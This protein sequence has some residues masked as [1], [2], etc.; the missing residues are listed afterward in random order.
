MKLES[1]S[2]KSGS[3]VYNIGSCHGFLRNYRESFTTIVKYSNFTEA[4][5]AY[6]KYIAKLFK[7]VPKVK[8]EHNPDKSELI[9]S[10]EEIKGSDSMEIWIKEAITTYACFCMFRFPIISGSGDFVIEEW[11]KLA[12]KYPKKS[13]FKLLLWL[14]N[15][16]IYGTPTS[17]KAFYYHSFYY[18]NNHL[19]AY[20]ITSFTDFLDLPI[21]TVSLNELFKVDK[22]FYNIN[23][24]R[25]YLDSIIKKL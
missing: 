17:S 23:E 15:Y 13:K 6:Y 22:T 18:Y 24:K 19:N 8:F 1:Y 14:N 16:H 4:D 11:Y 10:I 2:G 9:F 20:N 7:K 3:S 12:K 5:D 21:K 25:K